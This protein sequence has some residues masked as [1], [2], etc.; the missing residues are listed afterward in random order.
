[1]G[2]LKI[3]PYVIEK[4]L[5]HTEENRMIQTYQHAPLYEERQQAFDALGRKLA[6]L[7]DLVAMENVKIIKFNK[8]R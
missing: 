3:P 4:C 2:G 6:L 7:S 8:Y 5:N 1:M